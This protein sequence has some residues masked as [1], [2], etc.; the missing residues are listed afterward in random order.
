MEVE[1]LKGHDDSYIG[2]RLPKTGATYWLSKADADA[3]LKTSPLCPSDCKGAPGHGYDDGY[4]KGLNDAWD[5]ARKIITRKADGGLSG[6]DLVEVF[7][8]DVLDC[9]LD[10]IFANYTPAEAIAKIKAWEENKGIHVGDVAMFESGICGVVTSIDDDRF[11]G[12]IT[13][14]GAWVVFAEN[15]LKKTGR[16][17]DVAG[18]LKQIGGAE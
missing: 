4:E 17:I 5:A 8:E 1:I 11:A 18:F 2:Y 12:C 13:Q 10:T 9:T 15:R 16:S 14:E 3:A 6:L 7:G